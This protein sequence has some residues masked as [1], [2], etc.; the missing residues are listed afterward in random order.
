MNPPPKPQKP[1]GLN[2]P[3]KQKR[4]PG[5]RNECNIDNCGKTTVGFGMCE[6]HW[7]KWK[8]WGDPRHKDG[9]GRTPQTLEWLKENFMSFVKVNGDCWDW[10][11]PKEVFWGYGRI[12]L[13]GKS[14]K[15]HRASFLIHKGEIPS[16][17][18][19]CHTC[20]RPICVNPDHLFAGTGKD[21]ISD[22]VKKGRHAAQVNGPLYRKLT[23]S[24][25][26]EIY[27][28]SSSGMSNVSI[29]KLFNVL[30]SAI[31]DAVIGKTHNKFF[32]KYHEQ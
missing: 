12:V 10:L 14:T 22:C 21:N 27:K 26:V 24:D 30:R 5:K 20:D 16:G 4:V 3:E 6:S 18:Q 7:R 13:S 29:S 17:L 8:R 15:A 19:I 28:M 1:V 11:G 32:T 23:D 25:L 2:P 31:R 9:R